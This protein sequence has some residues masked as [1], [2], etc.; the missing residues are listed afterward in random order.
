MR[1]GVN[2]GEVLVGALRAGGDY[3]AMGD[4]VNTANRL[5]T[6]A[7][8]GRGAR[9]PGHL[10]RHQ[11][12]RA[13]RGARADRRQG[14]RG[15]RAGLAG[16][17][18]R[19]CRPGYRPERNRA[20]LIG[21]EPELGLLRHSVDNAVRNA[22][23]G[24]LLVL[25]EAGVG[26]SRLAEELAAARRRAS[27]TRSCSRAAACP[28]AR[29]TCGG[30][31][32]TRSATAAASARATRADTRDRAGRRGRCAPR[33]ARRATAAR[34]SGSSRAC[35]SSW[36]TSPSCGASTP[37]APGRRP[38]PRSSPSP[39]G[40]RSQRPV[41]V[42]LSDLHWADDLVLELVDTLL[43]RLC[44]RRFV[45]LAT[46]R[47]AIEE[48]WHPPHGRHN[49]VVLTLD[50]LTRR[51]LGRAAARAG[52]RAS[53]TTGWP[54]R[55][56][57]AAAATRSSS[58]S[59]SRSSARPGVV[60]GG[61]AQA[62]ELPD[63]LRG[64]VAARLDGLTPDERRVLDDCAVL[65]RRG[66]VTAIEVMS[67]KHLGHRGR[68]PGP[69][70]ARGQGAPR[71]QRRRRG[72]E[73]D[74]PLRP[75]AGGRLQH[76][77][78]GRSGQVPRRHRRVDGG[79]RGGRRS[80]PCST[81]SRSTTSGPPSW[82]PSSAPVDE[83][84]RRRAS[85]GAHWLERAAVRADQARAAGGGRAALRRGPAPARPAS[86]APRHRAFLT[87]RA[88]R[89]RPAARAG[90]RRG[91]TPRPR[92]TSRAAPAPRATGDLAQAL[93]ALADIEQKESALGRVRGR[94]GRGRRACSR[95]SATLAARPRC[96]ACAG[97][98]RSSATTTTPPLDAARGRPGRFEALGDRRGAAWA[99][100]NLAWC[101]FYLGPGRGGRGPQL[102]PAAATFEELGDTA[103]RGWAIGLL[104]WTRF[105][106][107]HSR[108]GRGD[109]RERSS[110][111]SAAAA[112]AGPP[113]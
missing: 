80:T 89:P 3:T 105:Q 93:L 101:A 38:P 76:A 6:A 42:V 81:A 92:S 66:P 85:T 47:R 94:A 97:S 83:P 57:S 73:V 43:E 61:H 60:G 109:G 36:A 45:V 65:G 14:P 96:S 98:A 10:R 41:V 31:S 106:Q 5:Q 39:S 70:V 69:R 46:A 74:L 24:L 11:P 30:R 44:T 103:G 51:R 26:K 27:T 48:R 16:P 87:G 49:L 18:R 33:S 88:A 104:A 1:V 111:R 19:R 95:G 21:R 7:A 84:S 78:Q 112:T 102:R 17:R 110:T 8:A 90:R 53:S 54:R 4:V 2:T 82:P 72:G 50:S 37:P 58:R 52:R 40:S 25:G 91:P 108:R 32:P 62:T 9:R 20:T 79:A 59:W 29:P 64:L 75:R 100:Q 107:G 23:A 13:L 63:T 35:S 12:G 34:S 22:R 15:A 55:C 67:K 71:P 68:P 99:Q 86:T 113:G 28:T 56:S 77:H